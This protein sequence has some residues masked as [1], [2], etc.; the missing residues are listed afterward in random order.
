MSCQIAN[1][2]ITFCQRSRINSS[3]DQYIL[4]LSPLHSTRQVVCLF[5]LYKL[6]INQDTEGRHVSEV[7]SLATSA[8]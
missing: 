6:N 1:L 3:V 7:G 5:Y 4:E 2:T 8:S